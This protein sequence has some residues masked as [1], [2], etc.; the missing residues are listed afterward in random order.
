[1]NES[2]F[3]RD[4]N[5]CNSIAS[6]LFEEKFWVL[7]HKD[8]LFCDLLYS[9]LIMVIACN[10][11]KFVFANLK[12]SFFGVLAKLSCSKTNL[13]IMDV[14]GAR[15]FDKHVKWPFSDRIMKP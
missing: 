10:A 13:F 3:S 8:Q 5:I 14:I 6:Y 1:M 4:K 15:C 12:H 9:T 7:R 2:Q 11:L